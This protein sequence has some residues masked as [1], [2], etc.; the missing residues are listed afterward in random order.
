LAHHVRDRL[1]FGFPH[2]F[3]PRLTEATLGL[4][5]ADLQVCG[6]V[7]P[8]FSELPEYLKDLD[9]IS[10]EISKRTRGEYTNVYFERRVPSTNA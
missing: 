4:V 1:G 6:V 5:K 7:L 3:G 2:G 9:G 10:L 8:R